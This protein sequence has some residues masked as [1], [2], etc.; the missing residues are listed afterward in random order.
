MFPWQGQPPRLGIQNLTAVILLV[1]LAGL[2]LFIY[3]WAF[4]LPY[5]LLEWYQQPKLTLRYFTKNDPQAQWWLVWAFLVQ[6]GLYWLGWRLALQAR[7]RAAWLTVLGGAAAFSAVLLF[8]Y[9]LDAADIFDNIMHG[10][11][12]GVYGAN[13]FRAVANQFADDPFYPYVAWQ[14]T[15]SAY[16]PIW[17]TLAGGVARLAGDGIIANVLAFKLLGGLF[18]AVGIGLVAVILRRLAPERALAG[19]TLLAWNPVVLYETIGNGHNDIAMAIWLLVAAWAILSRRYSLAVVALLLGVLIKFIPLLLIPLVGVIAWRDLPNTPARLRFLTVTT[20][21]AIALIVIAYGPF[22]YGLE[23]L[24]LDRRAK[25]FTASLPA[26]IHAWLQLNWGVKDIGWQI[27][28]IAASLTGL[29][30]LWQSWRTWR[31]RSRLNFTQAAFNILIFYLLVTCLWFQQWY[32]VWPL[33]MA[34]LLPPGHAPRLAILFSYAA[35]SKHLIFGPLLFWTL[36]RP[37]RS[38]L[39]LL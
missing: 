23:G 9:P 31:D 13:P 17:E 4:V 33:T 2:S 12:L 19:V 16:G 21:S 39:E 38:R 37:P 35:M 20:L 6:G 34:A 3:L 7:G 32:V 18:L 10:R 30:I 27:G 14:R 22:W 1:G 25:L 28:L 36:P 15:P 5:N 11:I 8:L 29:F 24:G 26:V